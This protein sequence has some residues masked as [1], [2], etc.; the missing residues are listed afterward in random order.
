MAKYSDELYRNAIAQTIGDI[1]YADGV[2]Y[3]NK[4]HS[5]RV[6]TE[7]YV[8]R[9][10]KYNTNSK[11]ELGD[12]RTYSALKKADVVEDFF[13]DAYEIIHLEGND[14][15]HSQQLQLPT[16][17]EFDNVAHA[18]VTIQAYLFYDY[19]KKYKFGSNKE[20]ESHFSLLP[21]LLR[22][23]VLHELLLRDFDN[24]SIIHKYGLAVMKSM[25]KEEA[26]QVIEADK[27]EFCKHPI[28]FT[29]EDAK[30]LLLVEKI[31]PISYAMILNS[32][33]GSVYDYLKR[34]IEKHGDTFDALQPMYL[35][36]EEAK[37]Y[38]I[39]KGK[40]AGNDPDVVEF[41]SL[42]DYLYIGRK[43]LE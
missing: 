31:D 6:L 22:L 13:W 26:L 30:N 7:Y 9:L 34:E 32:M 29:S 17:K 28:P 12:P 42:I 15:S 33:T 3:K 16:E 41:N 11:L 21:P 40:I 18:V 37:K 1:Y 23:I 27:E 10:T 14:S 4:I 39:E 43:I 35:T 20:I 36:F 2:S 8:R 25:G 19:F 24:M 5:M 38:Y